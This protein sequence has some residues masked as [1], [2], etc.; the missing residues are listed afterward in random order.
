MVVS[1]KY[2]LV[3]SCDT[4]ILWHKY[5]FCLQCFS[6]FN[7]NYFSIESFLIQIFIRPSHFVFFSSSASGHS[8]PIHVDKTEAQRR[9]E[10]RRESGEPKLSLGERER[11]DEDARDTIEASGRD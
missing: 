3:A 11:E 1:H 2:Y 4:I 9:R 7:V 6:N 10:E 5:F 8:R